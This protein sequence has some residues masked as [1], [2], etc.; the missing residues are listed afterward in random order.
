[1]N[2]KREHISL[3][4]KQASEDPFVGYVAANGKGSAVKGVVKE[5]T[6]KGATIELASSI[7][8]YLRASEISRDRVEDARSDLSVGDEIEAK[9]TSIRKERHNC[10]RLR[11]TEIEGEAMQ[12]YSRD[13]NLESVK[14]GEKLK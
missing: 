2:A 5:V 10:P 3:G 8:G 7:E 1:M 13:A 4:L 12:E 14:P 11:E 9:I 6:A